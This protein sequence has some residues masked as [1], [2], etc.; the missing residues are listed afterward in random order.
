MRARAASWLRWLAVTAFVRGAAIVGI[1]AFWIEHRDS[2]FGNAWV[3]VW[4]VCA[5]AFEV[6]AGAALLVTARGRVVAGVAIGLGIGGFAHLGLC[7]LTFV[8][9][10]GFGRTPEWALAWGV[11]DNLF[12]LVLILGVLWPVA[13]RRADAVDARHGS[14][15][16]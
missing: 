16:A 15:R 9:A 10:G 8:V 11:F 5:V 4:A 12:R 6:C 2:A 13:V 3:I 7:L 14:G 1:T